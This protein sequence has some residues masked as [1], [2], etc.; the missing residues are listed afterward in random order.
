MVSLCSALE[1]DLLFLFPKPLAGSSFGGVRE[2]VN[3]LLT[4]FFC[5]SA[6]GILIP[7]HS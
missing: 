5:V 7:K 6:F 2:G 1:M 3:R 4:L